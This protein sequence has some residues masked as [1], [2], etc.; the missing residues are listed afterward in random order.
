MPPIT[1]V[2]NKNRPSPV[3]IPAMAN[4]FLIRELTR[5]PAHKKAPHAAAITSVTTPL[6]QM[7]A[8]G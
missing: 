6:Q 1:R 7:N 3:A 2:Y 4:F 8:L 5:S